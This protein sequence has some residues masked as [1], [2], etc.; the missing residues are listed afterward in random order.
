MNHSTLVRLQDSQSKTLLGRR[1]VL[2]VTALI[3]RQLV[4]NVDKSRSHF[5]HMKLILAPQ[6]ETPCCYEVLAS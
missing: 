2:E 1:S 4:D 5:G 3:L 6:R